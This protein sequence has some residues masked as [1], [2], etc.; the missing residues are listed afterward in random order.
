[1]G[2]E[3]LTSAIGLI[4]ATNNLQWQLRTPS[5]SIVWQYNSGAASDIGM[6]LQPNMGFRVHSGY[7]SVD[8]FKVMATDV[9]IIG[10]PLNLSH[11]GTFYSGRIEVPSSGVMNSKIGDGAGTWYSII[12]QEYNAGS[13]KIGFFNA[14][15]VNKPSLAAAAT[16]AATTQ[17]LANS[18]RTALINLGLGA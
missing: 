8:A 5:Q 1:M 4:Q 12:R 13:P 11:N 7:G 10:V 2:I 14:T 16:D 17:T 9:S 18:L 6:T 15:P 3:F